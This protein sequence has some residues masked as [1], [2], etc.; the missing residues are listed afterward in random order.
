MG[1]LCYK[2]GTW[3]SGSGANRMKGPESSAYNTG[4]KNPKK[5]IK[6]YFSIGIEPLKM[7][8]NENNSVKDFISVSRRLEA[9]GFDVPVRIIKQ[10]LI[11]AEFRKYCSCAS[12][13]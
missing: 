7:N 10:C 6:N 5:T 9:E 12:Y 1:Y 11:P 13:W 8:A 4:K 2:P 3:Q